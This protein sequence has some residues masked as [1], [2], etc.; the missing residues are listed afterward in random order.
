MPAN[1][2]HGPDAPESSALL[3]PGGRGAADGPLAIRRP[4]ALFLGDV[5]DARMAK[6]ASGIHYWRP[7]DCIAQ[8]RLPGCRADLGLPDVSAAEAAGLG[9]QTLVIG[10]AP[11]GGG[12]PDTWIPELV[13]ALAAGLD[14]ASGMHARVA[15]HPAVGA[16]MRGHGT[17]VL[18]VRRAPAD[19]PVATGR[20]R[21]GKRL[22]TVGTDCGVGKMFAALALERELLRRGCR[23]DFRATGQTGILI[24][25]QGICI[26]AVVSDFAAGAAEV[27][28]PDNASD[29]WDV[30]E[31][32]GSLLHPSYAGVTLSLLHGSQPD[33]LIMCHDA[34][35]EY[36]VGVDGYRTPTLEECVDANLRAGRL[37]NRGIDV[38]GLC[39]NT[40]SLPE[41]EARGYLDEAARRL[42]V[43]ACDPVRTGVTAIVDLLDA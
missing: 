14:I 15:D 16:A 23:A 32:Q 27:L 20:K 19:L 4:Y 36:M 33:H 39:V 18:D 6:T 11:P 17:R 13:A 43:P 37:V 24:A 7:D 3:S 42:G 34:S 29:H 28:S 10:L 12:V 41:A 26:D 40:S 38:I 22:L 2:P 21:T 25:G 30:I 35:R 5:R 31:G 1:P 9:A 8:V